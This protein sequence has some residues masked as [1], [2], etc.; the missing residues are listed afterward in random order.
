MS[1]TNLVRVAEGVWVEPDLAFGEVSSGL[2]AEESTG[3]LAGAPRLPEDALMWS[4]SSGGSR[5][6]PSE[7]WTLADLAE[8]AITLEGIR[9]KKSE[10]F[11]DVLLS[12]PGRTFSSDEIVK[13]H[14]EVFASAFAVAGSLNGFRKHAERAG[15]A[16]PFHWWE[17]NGADTPTRYGIRPSVAEVFLAARRRPEG[18]R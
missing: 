13:A 2:L 3:E 17:G 7:Q 11:F 5:N 8:A 4:Y 15:R 1:P 12:D 10:V 18:V 14:P 6:E 9:G 16:F